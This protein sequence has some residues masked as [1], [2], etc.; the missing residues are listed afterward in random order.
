MLGNSCGGR[1]RWPGPGPAAPLAAAVG[2]V[3]GG[4]VGSRRASEGACGQLSWRGRS[5]EV[6]AEV[7]VVRCRG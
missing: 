4:P 3:A 7:E 2:S 5:D 6:V 1:W